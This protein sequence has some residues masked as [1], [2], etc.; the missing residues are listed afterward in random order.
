MDRLSDNL[1]RVDEAAIIAIAND[2]RAVVARP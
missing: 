1:P 2:L